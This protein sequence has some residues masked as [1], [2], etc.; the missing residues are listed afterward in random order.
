MPKYKC[1]QFIS[2]RDENGDK[3]LC[4]I[5]Q[6]FSKK[7]C[8][9]C[10]F[11]RCVDNKEEC[12]ANEDD[13]IKNM[14]KKGV[15]RI[16]SQR[17]LELRRYHA[18][19]RKLRELCNNNNIRLNTY[20]EANDSMKCVLSKSDYEIGDTKPYCYKGNEN[21]FVTE[22]DLDKLDELRDYEEDF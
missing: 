6:H 21:Y 14:S 7:F 4:R 5:V 18:Q 20:D 10:D 15:T 13:R 9:K 16:Q 3:W 1:G 19:V 2:M 17:E 12:T 8:S 22:S 11:Y